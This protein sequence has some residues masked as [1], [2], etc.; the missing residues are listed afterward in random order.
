MNILECNEP[1]A[2][3]TRRII[4]DKGFKNLYIAKKAGFTPQ[5]FSDMINGRRLIKVC[6]VS[7]LAYAL[8]VEVGDIYEA[9]KKEE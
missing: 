4:A 8:E 6:D 2:T 7:K 1:V 9:G 5:E 3:G